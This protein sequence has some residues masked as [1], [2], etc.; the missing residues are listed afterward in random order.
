MT[1]RAL[2]ESEMIDVAAAV[3]DMLPLVRDHVGEI[4]EGR[5][6]PDVVEDALRGTGIN[7]MLLPGGLGG[8]E[9]P[10][11]DAVEIFEH[12]A[13]VDGSTAWC[14]VIGA[15]SNIFAGYLPE[16]GAREVFADPDRSTATMFA[17]LGTLEIGDS[18]RCLRGR[19]PYV[20]NSLHA[21]W[22]GVVAKPDGAGAQDQRPHLVFARADDLC[23]EDTWHAVGLRGTGSHHVST[24]GITVDADHC[25]PFVGDP[26]P[27]GP[28]WR[29]PVFS[30][31]LPML[32]AVPLGIARG[33]LDQIARQIRDGRAA[34]RRGNLAADP[35]AMT[36]YAAAASRLHAARAGLIEPVRDAHA[37][38][39]RGEQ[40]DRRHLAHIY[41]ANLHATE[42]A[43]TVTA[44]AHRL[45]G[46]PAVF[47]DHPLQRALDDV[48]AARQHYQFA[49]DHR[50]PLGKVLAGLDDTYPPYIT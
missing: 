17:P 14:A 2:D 15:A 19:W 46:G 49:H 37:L 33:A 28:L 47:A 7:R 45:G 31:I 27:D 40:L 16:A 6:L 32:A 43:V 9:T 8:L 26:W 35:V 39:L 11:V 36:D 41:L 23:I 30:V 18:G 38:A 21:A 44:T 13:A 4:G 29:M 25:C 1:R 24:E 20:S 12:L 50:N 3:D 22:I 10:T 5:R 42:T 48:H 34:I